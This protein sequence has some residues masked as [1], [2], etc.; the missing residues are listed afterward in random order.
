MSNPNTRASIR[1]WTPCNKHENRKVASAQ[2]WNLA[3]AQSSVLLP[4]LRSRNNSNNTNDNTNDTPQVSSHPRTLFLGSSDAVSSLTTQ[5]STKKGSA[6]PDPTRVVLETARLKRQ[7]ESHMKCP[8][9]KSSITASF[10]TKLQCI[11]SS[12]RIECTNQTCSFADEEKPSVADVPM[13]AN[14]GSALKPRTIDWQTNVLYMLAFLSVGDGGTEAGRLLGLLGMP[15]ATTF[16]PRS[17]SIIEEHV[18]P[19]LQE[20]AN[21]LVHGKNLVEE[22]KHFFGDKKDDNNNSLFDLWVEKRLPKE[23]WPK[24]TVGGDMGWQKGSSG[25]A[26]SSL[27]GD[28]CL[29]GQHARKPIAWCVM[30]KC[31]SFCQGWKRGK[32]KEEP[33]PNHDCRANWDGSSGA[34]EPAAILE[35]HKLLCEKHHVV[36]DVMMTDDDSSIKATMKWS[37]ADTMTN[38]GLTE[39][40]HVFNAKGDKVVRPDKGGIPGHMP[41]PRFAADPNHRKKSLNN[42]LCQLENCNSDKKM[43]MTKMDVLRLGTNFAYMVRTLPCADRS[44]HVNKGKA[45]LEHH[46]D[47]HQHCGDWCSRKD[48]TEEQ[49]AN[50]KLCDELKKRIERFVSYEALLEVSHG[51]DTNANESF[52]N[53]VAWLAPKNKTHSKSESLKNRIAVAL[54]INAIGLLECYKMVFNKLGLTMTPPMHHYLQKTNSL[55]V[56]KIAAG[57]TS[58]GKK[59]RVHK[60]Q[61]NLLKKTVMA[62][63]EKFRRDGKHQPALGMSGGHADAELDMESVM[64]P[65]RKR[66]TNAA[67]TAPKKRRKSSDMICKTCE[68]CGH[69]MVTSSKCKHHAECKAWR[70]TK[71]PKGAKFKPTIT[72]TQHAQQQPQLASSVDNNDNDDD[73]PEAQAERD[74]EECDLMDALPLDDDG[75]ELEFFDAF[76]HLEEDDSDKEN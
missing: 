21:E 68:E 2:G 55:R 9:C 44:E 38:L 8:K 74:A 72:N 14:H 20:I 76:E 7:M 11:A 60:C 17:F 50:T 25:N 18:G 58:K 56:T 71:P 29:I 73:S 36:V 63:R 34:M 5:S 10:P 66:N 47:S 22:V 23:L 67:T 54:G 61:L 45:V 4:R 1:G 43:T 75:M 3:S 46:F 49:K 31:C 30:G 51:V 42:S 16:G 32:H 37:N 35:M 70:A 59:I 33:V 53:A 48:Q 27:S 24:V 26:Y 39:P 62:K 28:A 15:N 41:E 13:P 57:K 69:G 64:H 52:N 40:P 6:V 65:G 19:V 12:A